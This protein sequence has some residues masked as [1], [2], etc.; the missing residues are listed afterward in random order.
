MAGLLRERTGEEARVGTVEL[1]F[2]LV[3]VFAITQLSHS[4]IAH[5]GLM[6]ALQTLLLFL[7]I[8]WV[9]IF[10]CWVT[11]WLDPERWRVRLLLFA[12][13]ACGLVL[14]MRVPTAWGEGGLTF[15]IAYVTM[16]VGRSLYMAIVMRRHSPAGF[17]NF[18]RITLWLGVSGLF[19]IAGGLAEG[20]ARLGMW[21]VGLA[22]EYAGPPARFPVPGLGRSS[23][24]DWD[25][26]GGHMAERSGLFIII[27]LGE[28][29]LITGATMAQMPW[30]GPAL[31]A[32]ASAF[33]GSVAMWW[34][35]FNIGAA[36]AGHMIAHHEDPGRVARLA[37]TYAPIPIVAGIIVSAASDEMLLAHPAGHIAPAARAMTIGGAAL[38]LL[39][40]IAFK[41]ATWRN[42]P[43]SHLVGLG[44]L[45]VLALLPIHDGYA[46]GM[47]AALVLAIV[48]VWETRSLGGSSGARERGHD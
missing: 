35:Y 20:T 38:F 5:P 41:R 8:W 12:L 3:F 19:W 34:L 36:R 17:R 26:E 31:I 23:T 39:G 45:A 1:F 46:L 4:L 13:M 47:G 25:V 40:N 7:A 33:L 11:N 32:F 18:V 48:A 28:S 37:Y 22:I 16:Q 14:S 24:A 29:I 15:A 44:L 21:A 9:W 27:A 42:V 30:T 43:F 2:D 10:T 6:G